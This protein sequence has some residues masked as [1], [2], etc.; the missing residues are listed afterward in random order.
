MTRLMIAAAAAATFAA[1]ALLTLAAK[2]AAAPAVV[3]A[4]PIKA[5]ATK[6][7]VTGKKVVVRTPEG[8]APVAAPDSPVARYLH[9]GDVVRSC[10]EAIARTQSG[11]AYHKRGRGGHVLRI[12]GVVALSNLVLRLSD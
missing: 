10:V 2:A 6:W 1:T 7:K 11:P 9:R 4:A 12:V 8:N 5:C 3:V